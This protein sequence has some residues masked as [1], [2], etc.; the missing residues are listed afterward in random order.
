MVELVDTLVSGTSE[1]T[2]VEV[3]VLSSPPVCSLMDYCLNGQLLAQLFFRELT[4]MGKVELGC[5]LIALGRPW[6]ITPKLPS[7]AEAQ[8]FLEAAY[9]LGIRFFDT[10]P[11]YG[12][13]EERLGRFLKG[14][15]T[16]EL[17]DVRVAT[18]FGEYRDEA[19]KGYTDFSIDTVKRSIDR[20]LQLLGKITLLQVHKTSQELLA[21]PLMTDML[22]YAQQQG[23]NEFGLSITDP[24][25]ALDVM[26]DTRFDSIQIPFNSD[27]PQFSPVIQ[28]A[29]A[30]SK[31]VIVNRPFRRG[32]DVDMA[33]EAFRLIVSEDFDG[34][35]LTGTSNVEHLQSNLS[36]FLDV[37]HS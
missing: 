33:R 18:K 30:V 20:S 10:A 17:K 1:L 31:E 27:S 22:A 36:T 6:G 13:S 2:L 4:N 16:T 35:V 5:G 37:Q 28:R 34:V 15:T 25:V 11:S 26:D 3:Q 29:K 12:L 24:T 32:Q 23:V 14:L 21:D 7:D 9:G 19:G 8:V